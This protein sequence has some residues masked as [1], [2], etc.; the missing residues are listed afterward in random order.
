[1]ATAT[2]QRPRRESPRQKA[3]RE[4]EER[5]LLQ[6]FQPEYRSVEAARA[7]A[8]TQLNKSVNRIAGKN[9]GAR[10]TRA[11]NYFQ[12]Q[13]LYRLDSSLPRLL[14]GGGY[15]GEA[16]K[17]RETVGRTW[18]SLPFKQRKELVIQ[19]IERGAVDNLPEPNIRG[20]LDGTKPTRYG[21]VGTWIEGIKGYLPLRPDF[22]KVYDDICRQLGGPGL[23]EH[24]RE[25]PAI[26]LGGLLIRLVSE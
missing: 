8:R 11:R 14:F 26:Y 2:A 19:Y 23:A 7:Y 20:M 4:E 24:T 9:P 3:K 10:T 17:L 21:V 6:A 5:I 22:D 1:M 25:T 18:N 12:S 15:Q 13:M 16:E